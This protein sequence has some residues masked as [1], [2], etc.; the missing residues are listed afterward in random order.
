MQILFISNKRSFTKYL[1]TTFFLKSSNMKPKAAAK[2]HQSS[3]IEEEL[4]KKKACNVKDTNHDTRGNLRKTGNIKI[5]NETRSFENLHNTPTDSNIYFSH[6]RYLERDQF[7]L[8][9]QR[10]LVT[11]RIQGHDL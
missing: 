7:L 6:C 4:P 11:T 10:Q 5:F 8:K 9:R 1:T 2:K 3:E